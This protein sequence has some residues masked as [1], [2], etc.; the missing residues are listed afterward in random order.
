[1]TR[2]LANLLLT[3]AVLAWP[4]T[5]AQAQSKSLEGVFNFDKSDDI[6]K[7]VDTAISEMNPFIKFVARGRLLATNKPY[8]VITIA[9]PSGKVSLKTDEREPIV[10]PDN[11]TPTPWVRPEDREAMKVSFKLASPQ[12]LEESFLAEDGKRVNTFT[13]DSNGKGMTMGVVVT[14]SKLPQPLRY[15]VHYLRK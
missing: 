13:L 6:E 10:A 4:V 7:A 9:F 5:Q 15:E 12:R 1:M 3:L 2:K 11:G 8:Q 14:S